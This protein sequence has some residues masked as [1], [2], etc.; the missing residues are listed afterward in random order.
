MMEE[1]NL[2]VNCMHVIDQKKS[3]LWTMKKKESG[4]Q[5][6]KEQEKKRK[7]ERVWM[8]NEGSTALRV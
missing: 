5:K 6:G 7:G 3:G 1:E 4:N 2:K 8:L